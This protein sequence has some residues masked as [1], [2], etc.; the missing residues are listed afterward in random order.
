MVLELSIIKMD[1]KE[2]VKD[3]NQRFLTLLKKI[4]LTYKHVD[5]LSIEFYT[6]ALLFSM[7]MFFKRD[8]NHTLDDTFKEAIKVEKHMQI[9]KT[10][11]GEDANKVK[12]NTKKKI[13]PPKSPQGK[14]DQDSLDM[15][16][17][18]RII[19]KLS[20]EI[21]DMNRNTRE[22]TSNTKKLFKFPPKK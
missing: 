2:K 10:N 19:K 12:S 15:E 17:L 11:P 22:G 20:N 14:K 13:H 1:A 4:P 21:V 8:K 18:Q 3:F 5:G 16:I 6:L 7:A 9:L